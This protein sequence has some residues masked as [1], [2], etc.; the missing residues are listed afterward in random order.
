MIVISVY[1]SYIHDVVKLLVEYYHFQTFKFNKEE[2]IEKQLDSIASM[3]E[4]GYNK[5]VVYN[6]Q[7]LKHV[8]A[9]RFFFCS[10]VFKFND[11][12][13]K[14][15]PDYVFDESKGEYNTLKQVLDAMEEI[16]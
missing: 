11:V 2:D 14:L 8:R 3:I 7:D 4:D 13:P 16:M 12:N 15:K 10:I 5:I 1:G 6:L 9:L